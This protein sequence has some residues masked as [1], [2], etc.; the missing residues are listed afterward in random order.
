MQ[1]NVD[2]DSSQRAGFPRSN[3]PWSSLDGILVSCN[4]NSVSLSLTQNCTICFLIFLSLLAQKLSSLAMLLPILY[5][6]LN[7]FAG[8]GIVFAN[9]AVLSRPVN[10][11][12]TYALTLIHTLTTLWG[13]KLFLRFGVFEKKNLP[14]LA[15]LPL[16]AAY[17]ASIVL[18]NLNLQL[19]TVSFYTITK[20]LN[21]PAVMAIEFVLFGEFMPN[22]RMHVTKRSLT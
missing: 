2:D 11:H 3:H 17:V 14:K 4:L 15:V 22:A 8:N 18:S 12:F 10:F 1:W 13:M 5:S 7:L 19:N 6:F 16:S 20:I 9:K 21:G